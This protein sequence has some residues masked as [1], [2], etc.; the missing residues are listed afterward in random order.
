[1]LRCARSCVPP[2]QRGSE[3]VAW[4]WSYTCE[5]YE[6]AEQR[7]RKL[8]RSKLHAIY[9]EWRAWDGKHGFDLLAYRRALKAAK[10]LPSDVLCDY[11]WEQAEKNRTCDNGGYRLWMCPH[12]CTPHCVSPDETE[13]QK[14]NTSRKI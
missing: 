1:M 4:G 11:I 5:A 14:E 9:A 12:G 10:T 6:A 13:E 8:P 3:A 7:L 2:R